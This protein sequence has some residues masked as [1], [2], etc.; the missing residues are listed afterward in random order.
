MQNTNIDFTKRKFK[1]FGGEI[2][3]NIVEYLKPLVNKGDDMRIIVGCDS[4]Q[5]RSYTL[6]A[7]VIVLYDQGLHNGAHI[8]FMRIKDKKEKSLV[9]RLMNESLYSLDLAEYLN[10]ELND[11]YNMP[12]FGKC[13]YNDTT[14][15]KKIEIHVD[16]NPQEGNNKQNKSN[17]VYNSI[18]GMV[19]SYGFMVK[20]KPDAFGASCAADLLC[21]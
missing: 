21:K 13:K 17:V 9:N 16:V 11:F 4:Q 19:S 1:K 12:K 3:E 6:Y 10:N 2:I 14:P 15:S 5:K 7:L 8:V 18:M 20:C